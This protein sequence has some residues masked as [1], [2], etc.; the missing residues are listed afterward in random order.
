VVTNVVDGSS[1]T[2]NCTSAT[3]TQSP[4]AGA[5]LASSEGQTHVITV[6]ADDGNGNSSTCTVTLTGDDQ[7]APTATCEADATISLNGNCELIVT[8][9]VDGTTATDNCDMS[10]ALS[11]DIAAGT[12]LASSEGQTHVITVTADDGNGN[13]STCTVTLTGDDTTAPAITCEAAQNV[14]LNASCQVIVPDLIDGATG[15]DACGTVTFTQSPAISAALASAHNMTHVITVTGDDGNGNTSSCTVTLTGKDQTAPVPAPNTLGF[16]DV[17]GWSCGLALPSVVATPSACINTMTVSKPLFNDNCAA[18]VTITQTATAVVPIV[19]SPTTQTVA[20]PVSN[21]GNFVSVNFPVGI[22][23]LVF[24]GTD[25]GGNTAS[26]SLTVT[27]VDE[28]EPEL[29]ACPPNQTVPNTTNQ[30]YAGFISW[31]PPTASDNCT[32]FA[33]S[34]SA[35]STSNAA[36]TAYAATISG[37]SSV[38]MNVPVGLYTITYLVTDLSGNTDACTFTVNVV[39]TQAP[40]ANCP[41]NISQDNDATLCSA[42][43]NFTVPAPNDN[44]GA[45]SVATPASGSTFVVGVTTVTVVATDDAGNT[46]DCTFT[47]TVN[48]VEA[49]VANCPASITTSSDAGMCSAVVSFTVPAPNDNCGATSVATPASGSTFV[50]GVTTVTVVATDAAGNTDDCTFSVTVNDNEAPVANCPANITQ[51][52]DPTLCSA[53]VTF[54]ATAS[55]NCP[56][57][58]VSA[59]PASGSTF[60]VGVTTVNVLATDA[61]GNTDDCSFT[62][63]VN[64]TEAPT[65][66][67]PADIVTNNDAGM[68]SAV[69]SFTVPAAGDNCGATSVATPASGSTFVVGMTTVTVVATDAAGNTDD[70]TFS[71]TVNDNEAPVANCPA[72][73]TTSND[74][75]MCSAVVNFTVPAA[76][77][78]CG[79]TSVATPASGTAFAVGV[80]TVTVVATDAAGN[81]DDCTFSVTVNDTELPTANC[82]LNIIQSN[83][84]TLCSAVVTFTATATDNCPGGMVS[85]TPASGSTFVVG[86]TTVNVLVTD[87]SGNTDD[88][89]FTVTVNDT[90]APTANCPAS[91]TTNNDAGMCSA[92]VSFT[93]PAAGDNC[94]ATSVATPASGST[95]V[96]GTT[97][98]TVVAT[99][100][101]GNTDDCTFSVTVNDNEAPVANCPAS[102]TT[103]NDAGMCSAVVS[104]TVP[105]AGDNCSATSVATPAS[106]STFPVGVTT[107]TVVATDAA[108]NTDDCTFS[109]TV[110]DNEAPTANCPANMTQNNDLGQCSAVVTFTTTLSDNCPGGTVV[111]TPASGSTF[112]V[113]MTT[114]NVLATDAAGNTDDCSFVVTV[115]DTEAP[116]A[117][118]PANITQSNDPTLCSAVVNFTVPAPNDNCGATSVATPAS[119]STFVVGV[120]TVTVVAT[121]AAGN[122]DDCTFTVTVNDT[123]A[124]VSS[125]TTTGFTDIDNWACGTNLTYSATPSACIASRTVST[126]SFTDN[127]GGMPTVAFSASAIIPIV[128]SPATMM[129]TV[130]V[131]NFGMF[132]SVNFPVGTSTL[133]FVGTDAYGNTANCNLTVVVTDDEDPELGACPPNTTVPNTTGQCLATLVA[134][135]PPT[136]S[137]NCTGVGVSANAASTSNAASMAYAA[138]VSGATSIYTNVPVG[139]YTITYLATDLSGNTDDCTFTVTVADT[140]PPVITTCPPSVAVN[141]NVNPGDC[142]GEATWTAATAAD[143]CTTVTLTASHTNGGTFPVGVTNV[144]ITATDGAG[145]TATCGLTVTVNDNENPTANCPADINQNV[146]AGLCTA[147]VN[148]TVPAPADNCGVTSVASPASG[149]AFPVGPTVVT[150]T[151]TDASGNTGICT[152]TVTITENEA[153]VAICPANIT[154]GNDLGQ[155]SAVVTF[156]LGLST[157]NCGVTSEVATPAS[158]S[159]FPVGTTMVTVV[160]TDAAGNTD[161]CTFSV[162]VNDTEAPVAVCPANITQGNDAGLCSAVV[163]F[164]TSN[165]TDNCAGVTDVA[166]PASGS[167]FPVG[168]TPVTIVATDAVGNT[169]DCTFTVTVNDTEA[170]VAVC[171]ANITQGNDAG[172]CSAVV[173][174]ATGNSTDNCPG[175]SDVA[176]PASGSVFAFGTTPVT[177]VAT[178]AAG[179]THDCT[180][181]VTVNDTENPV[182]VCPANITQSNDL[183]LC[184]AVV[185]FATGNSTDNCPGVTDVATPAS[186]TVFSVGTT[187]VTIAATDAVGNTHECTFTVTVND[188]ETPVAICPADITTNNDAGLCSAVVTFAPTANDNCGVATVVSSPASGSAFAVGTTTVTVVATDIHGNTGNCTFTVTVYDNE[189]PT[190]SCPSD[191]TYGEC[192]IGGIGMPTTGDNCGVASVVSNAPMSFPNGTTIVTWTVTD[193]HGNTNSCQQTVEIVPTPV[194]ANQH[195]GVCSGETTNLNL[196]S[197]ITSN[198][199]SNTFTWTVNEPTGFVTGEAAGSGATIAQTLSVSIPLANSLPVT[200]TVTPTSVPFGCVGAPFTVVV[201]VNP[202]PVAQILPNGD[203]SLC[204]N[205]SRILLSSVTGVLPMTYAWSIQGT[206]GTATATLAGE[207]TPTPTLTATGGSGTVTIQVFLTDADGCSSPTASTITFNISQNPAAN[208]I[209][210][211]NAPCPSSILPYSV[212]NNIGNTYAWTLG[213]GG[214]ITTAP[215][216]PSINVQWIGVAGGPHTLTV[217]ETNAAGCSTTN[218]YDVTIATPGVE[219]CNGLDDDCDGMI[220]DGVLLAY[221]EDNDMDSYGDPLST[222]ILSCTVPMGNYVANDDDCNDADAGVNPG[223]TEICDNMVDEDCDSQVGGNISATFTPYFD[224]EIGTLNQMN[225]AATGGAG[226]L[227]YSM[228]G[229]ASATQPTGLFINLAAGPYTFA[230]TD[231]EGCANTQSVTFQTAIVLNSSVTQQVSCNGGNNGASTMTFVSGGTGPFT[232]EFKKSGV[233]VTP[234]TPIVYGQTVNNSGLTSGNYRYFITDLTTGCVQQGSLVAITQPLKVNAMVTKVSPLCNGESNG[235]VTGSATGGTMPYSFAWNTGDMTQTVNGLPAGNYTVTVT[236]VNGCMD[237]QA[238]VLSQPSVLNV[239]FVKSNVTCGGGNNGSITANPSGGTGTKTYNWSNGMTTQT[240][241][242]LTAGTY[243]VTVTD[244]NGCTK[245]GTT[246]LTEPATLTV[247]IASTN[248]NCFG[249]ASGSVTANPVGGTGTKTYAWSFG[250]NTKTNSGLT[251]GT[252]TVTVTDAN[253]CQAVATA[254]L[255]NPSAI[256]INSITSMPGSPGKHNVTVMASGGTPA[257]KYSRN[258]VTFQVSNVFSNLN[259]GT[260]T[261]TVRDAKNCTVSQTVAIPTM[262]LVGNPTTDGEANEEVADRTE[263][264][265]SLAFDLVPNPATTDVRIV[266]DGQTPENAMFDVQDASGKLLFTKSVRELVNNGN[267]LSLDQLSTGV[268]FVTMRTEGMNPV[269]KRLVVLKD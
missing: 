240:I 2:D 109:V 1:A 40:T 95:F 132:V 232:Y 185:T 72:S 17:D 154:Q 228:S 60:V 76:G 169:H 18:T 25:A 67:C 178:D 163:T 237:V 258:G 98:V 217:V 156:A 62:V 12:A 247:T 142:F 166:T 114:V 151:A 139:V 249:E 140:E 134:W 126:P 138:M 257:L 236:D 103:N 219:V 117:N 234:A 162:T 96:V 75:G 261:F 221:Y 171:P 39:D 30:C 50:V 41:A 200:Y 235:S 44:C 227:T 10:V 112:L 73:I 244:A 218:T 165:S 250:S 106:G 63:T 205:E 58:M 38:Y 94:G 211:N 100:A 207:T 48:D 70:C 31:T 186:G 246:S 255:T 206:T 262:M 259:P 266:F 119:G 97:T 54:M 101:A 59:T 220:D 180:F 204:G 128:P 198:T 131:S 147:V 157:D 158:G 65:A 130:P 43:V 53:V 149:T 64:D 23:T 91:I 56:G 143:N 90:E 14:V 222:P 26:C 74:A 80:T 123:E 104:F 118:C 201:D 233:V 155:C 241:N 177:I 13:S 110:N 245:V 230:V 215:T 152:F 252:Y 148:F 5:A 202:I 209:S 20:V 99:D 267:R 120:T 85:A 61:A 108:G 251:A 216:G 129:V 102:I 16:P 150:V 21:F 260:Y 189:A 254:V 49:P 78:N 203:F 9:V 66:N 167:V 4:L 265:F 263:K 229:T 93:V 37:A 111:A 11:Q 133:T 242:G 176:T 36:S 173:T 22:T 172:Q 226:A 52:N 199:P 146:D 256:V 212:A 7:S 174:F 181:T 135:T 164:A 79:A 51:A 145:N 125:P 195:T 68:C 239:N 19:P 69:V 71:V 223:A 57:G 269:T 92:V 107:V 137:D 3:L 194:G 141:S 214:T 210:G 183:G 243:T 188:T 42:V 34:A 248:P 82:P 193:I 144:T 213:S 27:V 6:T 179:N 83:D 28:E 15:T 24:K 208:A 238:S 113:G 225:I 268:V 153:P 136:A 33:L 168:T 192:A 122:T 81:T 160:A 253:G 35:V 116:V 46:D 32:G 115:N 231:A 8:D 197:F 105:A 124:P 55:D 175:Q 184:S 190:I 45:T 29:G 187:P 127:C 196:Q 47:V 88:C 77:D 87:A 89:S 191:V 224:C 121:D 170:P 84:P 264:A 182:A 159:V 86:V 161:D